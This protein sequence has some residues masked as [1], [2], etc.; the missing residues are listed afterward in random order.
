[1]AP[2][3]VELKPLPFEEAIAAFR[4]RA[5]NPQA[6][7]R[8][9]DHVH[10]EHASIFTVARSM[11][12][13][14]LGDISDALDKAKA[15]GTT[16]AE[17]SKT[18][19]P[20]LKAKGWWGKTVED[21]GSV[22]QLGS[23]RRLELIFN[24]NMR[25][26]AAAG[27]W[28]QIKRTQADLP[29]L[30]YS[31]VLDRRTRPA[32]RAWHGT[33][34]PVDHPWWNTH[35]PPCGWNCRCS[36]I[37]LSRRQAERRGI[38]KVPPGG[39]SK[40]WTNPSTGQTL[41]V[42]YGIDPGWGY[43]PGKAAEAVRFAEEAATQLA[44][45]L[46]ATPAEIAAAPLTQAIVEQLT[47]AF[48]RWLRGLDIFRVQRDMRVV[49]AFSQEVLDFLAVRNIDPGSGAITITHRAVAHILRDH[50]AN[51]G[52]APDIDQ[53]ARLPS[54]IAKPDAILW[55]EEFGRPVYVVEVQGR[56]G[57]RYVVDIAR[58]ETVKDPATGKRTA[59]ASNTIINGQLMDTNALKDR[60]RYTVIAGKI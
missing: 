18:L 57:T 35:Y 3:V 11:G 43:N 2:P 6:S 47:V 15:N 12:Y 34:L 45:K 54:L 53:L 58:P 52:L 17:F 23:Q 32:H 49:G 28:E 36:V 40:T 56:Q 33:V 55:N 8:W 4:R 59:I 38:T 37:Q 31:A 41:E 5:V 22:V 25:V 19:T 26:S 21:D 44:Q 46:I 24:V 13:D 29:Y 60:R 10:D 14:I 16:I 30:M 20:V 51:L 42:P 1:M 48:G 9:T 7:D 50:K 39:P 27:R